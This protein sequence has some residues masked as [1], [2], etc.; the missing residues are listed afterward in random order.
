MESRQAKKRWG[1][2]MEGLG[3]GRGLRRSFWSLSVER[4]GMALVVPHWA[5]KCGFG[6]G[7]PSSRALSPAWT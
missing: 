3:I 4:G 2:A 6:M 5:A 1:R 7:Q